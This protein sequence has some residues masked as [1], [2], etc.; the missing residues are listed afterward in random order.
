MAK[1]ST[2]VARKDYPAKGIKKGDLYYSWALYKQPKQLSLTRPRPSQLTSSDKLSRAYAIVESIED[3][4]K[5]ATVPSDLVEALNNAA[6]EANDLAD[7]Y[8]ESL[9][10]MPEGLQ[11]GPTGEEIQMKVD[12]LQSYA[13]ELEDAASEIEQLDV[14]DYIDRDRLEEEAKIKLAELGNVSPTEA[15]I[16]TVVERLAKAITEFE[17]LS[18]DE[19]SA[20][21]QAA[22]ELANVNLEI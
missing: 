19:R 11:Q 12:A 8:Q 9:D 14:Q 6:Q 13:S 1:V 16:E 20:M 4:E 17:E 15:A 10:N 3:A 7:E 5:T 22:C 21:L 2:Q 18:E